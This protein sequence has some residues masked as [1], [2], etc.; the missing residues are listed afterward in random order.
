MRRS[1]LVRVDESEERTNAGTYKVMIRYSVQL[2]SRYRIE[3]SKVELISKDSWG[4]L[5]TRIGGLSVG[6]DSGKGS[7]KKERE[8]NKRGMGWKRETTRR[9]F[10]SYWDCDRA[11]DGQ[12]AT[13]TERGERK[14]RLN[15]ADRVCICTGITVQI[16][17]YTMYYYWLLLTLHYLNDINLFPSSLSFY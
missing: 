17:R 1:R 11:S 13:R 10:D 5:L 15:W 3:G 2:D 7:R 14:S 16:A 6:R 12:R 9:W 8:R 4:W